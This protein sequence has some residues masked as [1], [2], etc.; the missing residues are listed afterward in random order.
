MEINSWKNGKI[1][2]PNIVLDLKHYTKSNNFLWNFE[3]GREQVI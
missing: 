1:N 3:E 2:W